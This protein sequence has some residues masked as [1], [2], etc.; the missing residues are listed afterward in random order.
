MIVVKQDSTTKVAISAANNQGSG[1]AAIKT[2]AGDINSA[3][4]LIT[5]GFDTNIGSS[6]GFNNFAVKMY[7]GGPRMGELFLS[8]S[9]LR[10]KK[11]IINWEKNNIL[12]KIKLVNP[13]KFRYKNWEN[14]SELTLGLIAEDLRD[15]ELDEAALH[16]YDENNIKQSDVEGIDWE[17][18]SVI[19]WKGVQEL[20]QRIETLENKISGSI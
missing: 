10:H 2:T 17:K 14:D 7:T 8:T 5:L 15:N 11:D 4:R 18:I 1:Y 6:G 20:T 12:D 3:G 19:L 13:K 16:K 9:T